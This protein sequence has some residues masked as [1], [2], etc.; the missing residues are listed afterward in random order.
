MVAYAKAVFPQPMFPINASGVNA[1]DTT[2]IITPQ[3]E[4]QIRIDEH[5][6][7]RN[8]LWAR[9]TGVTQPQTSSGGFPGLVQ[10]SFYHGYNLGAGYMRSMGSNSVLSLEFG[11]NSVQDNLDLNLPHVSPTL[12]QQVGFSPNF[13]GNFPSGGTFLPGMSIP[14]F[15]GFG[16]Y[17]LQNLHASDIWEVRGDYSII[18][19]HHLI[20]TGADFNT[21]NMQMPV[22]AV[23]DAFSSTQTANLERNLADVGSCNRGEPE[24]P[25]AHGAHAHRVCPGPAPPRHHPAPAGR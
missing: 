16:G 21:N 8:S 22:S 2:P 23:F 19:G 7:S 18:R 20:Q 1:V 13:A 17:Y 25:D 4:G 11:R 9:Y 24:H 6:N 15:V 3:D 10:N 5:L 12:W 14:G